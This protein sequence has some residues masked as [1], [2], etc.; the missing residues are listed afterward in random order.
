MKK[1][2]F[3]ALVAT[4][5]LM[6]QPAAAK[7]THDPTSQVTPVAKTTCYTRLNIGTT[8]KIDEPAI[9]FGDDQNYLS[10]GIHADELEFISSNAVI[11][12]HG[13]QPAR[14]IH[15]CTVHDDAAISAPIDNRPNLQPKYEHY[16]Q[17]GTLQSIPILLNT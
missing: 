7:Y 15:N 16:A 9:S 14:I 11:P 8:H 6:G 10:A 12:S 1:L 5:T 13:R 3:V 17:R 2:F 4:A